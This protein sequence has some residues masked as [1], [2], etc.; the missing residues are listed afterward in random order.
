[1]PCLHCASG[2][3]DSDGIAAASWQTLQVRWLWTSH[4]DQLYMHHLN[5]SM[6]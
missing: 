4:W 1:M 6:K 5:E 2:D 3:N